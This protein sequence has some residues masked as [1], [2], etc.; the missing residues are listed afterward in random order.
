M[1]RGGEGGRGEEEEGK[2]EEVE[3]EE[4]WWRAGLALCR[5]P[6]QPPC[7]GHMLGL[8]CRQARCRC[9]R[10]PPCQKGED[11]GEES[12]GGGCHS[13]MPSSRAQ[14]RP[15][16]RQPGNPPSIAVTEMTWSKPSIDRLVMT[17]PRNM[18]TKMDLTAWKTGSV[19][20]RSPWKM[21]H[22]LDP[23]AFVVALNATIGLTKKEEGKKKAPRKKR[24]N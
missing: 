24:R 17:S 15:Q 14:L 8:G 22:G 23:N 13:E 12:M 7:R 4:W 6:R 11:A 20:N 19:S 16:K 5:C 10:Q 2:V 18:S 21:R 9:C 3:E 1:W